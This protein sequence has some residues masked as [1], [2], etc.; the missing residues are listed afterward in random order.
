[1][2]IAIPGYGAST[3]ET[4]I[5]PSVEARSG[6]VLGGAPVT[7][8]GQWRPRP[9]KLSRSGRSSPTGR[10]LRV[11]VRPASAVIVTLRRRC[12]RG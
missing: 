9:V 7:G 5:G 1:V 2:R 6:I 10:S 8:G 3:E 4:L 12:S 11:I